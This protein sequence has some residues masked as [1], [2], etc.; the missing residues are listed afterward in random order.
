MK[1]KRLKMLKS[2]KTISDMD[3]Y[4][5]LR[6]PGDFSGDDMLILVDHIKNLKEGDNYLEIGVQYGKSAA[7]AIFSAIEGV[8]IYLCDIMDLGVDTKLN[9]FSRKDYFELEGLDKKS[10]FILGD[11]KKVAKTWDKGELSLI[12]ID[13]DHFY[14]AVKS[15]I[16]GWFPHLKNGGVMLFHDYDPPEGAVSKAVNEL[17]RDSDKFKDFFIGMK[18]YNIHSSSIV[19][20]TKNV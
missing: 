8:N 1:G 14:G 13:G 7:I 12:F 15:D 11:S 20:A 16:L 19:G 9:R 18:K 4:I 2:F 17:V 10:T 3:S 6:I 5:N